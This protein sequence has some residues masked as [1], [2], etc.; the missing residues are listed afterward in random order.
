MSR[1]HQNSL[2]ALEQST[3][4]H[5]VSKA[6]PKVRQSSLGAIA[7]SVHGSKS[8]QKMTV[9][10]GY[11]TDQLSASQAIEQPESAAPLGLNQATALEPELPEH[12]IQ[13]SSGGVSIS[14]DLTAKPLL[15]DGHWVQGQSSFFDSFEQQ[16]GNSPEAI[17]G[18]ET[19]DEQESQP[20]RLAA[21]EPQRAEPAPLQEG[22]RFVLVRESAPAPAQEEAKA[23]D[24]RISQAG[25]MMADFKERDD[26][27]DFMSELDSITAMSQSRSKKAVPSA[28]SKEV[29][30]FQKELDSIVGNSGAD[31]TTEQGQQDAQ[32]KAEQES[33]PYRGT[34][35]GLTNHSVFDRLG[36]QQPYANSFNLGSVDVGDRFD[37]F[38]VALEREEAKTQSR[39][40]SELGLSDLDVISDLTEISEASQKTEP[41][42]AQAEFPAQTEQLKPTAPIQ[43][44]SQ[45]ALETQE[46]TPP[47]AQQPT[48][49][50]SYQVPVIRSSETVTPWA[51]GAAM[52][53]G[54]QGQWSADQLNQPDGPWASYRELLATTDASNLNQWPI[55]QIS[56]PDSFT[57]WSN[58]LR[59]RGPLLLGDA[60][61]VLV[62]TELNQDTRIIRPDQGAM[63]VAFEDFEELLA[64]LQLRDGFI[65]AALVNESAPS[66]QG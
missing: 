63:E 4:R 38:D 37:Q 50:I 2:L 54:W 12:H 14:A 27:D 35:Q 36:K 6:A 46:E 19:E 10:S 65:V 29:D 57:D 40:A 8:S 7:Q 32:A 20:A 1:Y 39:I 5:G 21:A 11:F 24:S 56:A 47:D 17:F 42:P 51:A 16:E 64:R 62:L 59:E 18:V 61:Q 13:M 45:P 53:V 52:L 23:P 60:D 48:E 34:S 30:A 15:P 31:Q 33:T 26:T 28:Y 44:E 41:E 66:E 3:H 55:E 43:Q 49:N 22:E 9:V 58:L 25:E